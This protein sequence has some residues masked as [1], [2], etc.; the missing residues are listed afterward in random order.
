[1]KGQGDAGTLTPVSDLSVQLKRM[2]RAKGQVR[3]EPRPGA[4]GSLGLGARR[5]KVNSIPKRC[6]MIGPGFQNDP[7]CLRG[8]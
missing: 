6:D 7:P 3:D 5:R 8:R 2:R 1:M 4:E